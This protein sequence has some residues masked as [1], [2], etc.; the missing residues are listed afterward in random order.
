MTTN[1]DKGRID[2]AIEALLNERSLFAA[3]QK[4]DIPYSSFRRLLSEPEFQVSLREART[5]V[6]DAAL[7][8]LRGLAEDAIEVISQVV[9]GKSDSHL[10]F[11][12]AK[13]VIEQGTAGM[14]ADLE[15]RISELEAAR[16]S[17]TG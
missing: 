8:R 9:T 14:V 5:Q 6:L 16:G 13:W 17:S 10:R 1:L 7:T 12:A 11:S 4:A 3:A 2:R 15:S